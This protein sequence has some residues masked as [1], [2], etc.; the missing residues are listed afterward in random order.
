MEF[1]I[2]GPV[3]LVG[4]GATRLAGVKQRTLLAALLLAGG[5]VLSDA[6]LKNRLWGTDPPATVTAQLYAHVSELRKRLPAGV[7]LERR[8]PGYR[9]DIG[10]VTLDWHLFRRLAGRG[11]AGLADG[12]HAQAAE[13]LTAALELRRGPALAGVTE[14]L[15]DAE[16]PFIEEAYTAALE[17]RIDADLA[18]GRHT[19]LVPELVRLVA[20]NPVRERLRGQLMTA[21]HRC[22]RK[23]DALAVYAESRR[24][25]RE[26]LGMDPGHDLRRLH[27]GCPPAAR[28]AAARPA[29]A[30]PRVTPESAP[31]T[32]P[33]G[34]RPPAAP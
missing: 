31:G 19:S 1:R 24:V 4:D 11:L 7:R 33:A 9:L 27:P 14:Q 18:L 17:S 10:D 30:A 13:D 15:V 16:G 34:Q 23:A 29:P 6:L 3:E 22:G 12:R 28:P 26:E 8:S 21:L 20:E 25:L 32:R 5:R 2:L